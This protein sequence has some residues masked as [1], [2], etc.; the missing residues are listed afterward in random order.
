MISEFEPDIGMDKVHDIGV[1][2]LRNPSVDIIYFFSLVNMLADDHEEM[3]VL[4]QE[5]ISE[6][7]ESR[8]QT[9]ALLEQNGQLAEQNALL[10]E[11]VAQAS[12][13]RTQKSPKVK[14]SVYTKVTGC[15]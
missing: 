5:A 6:M 13:Q 9:K 7:K 8:K 15:R 1:L 3:A 14:V 4:L 2:Y 12:S 10:A 11:R